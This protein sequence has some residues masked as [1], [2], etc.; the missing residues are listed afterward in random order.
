[1][2]KRM[3]VREFLD[4]NE[5]NILKGARIKPD[6]IK[7]MVLDA[8]HPDLRRMLRIFRETQYHN[9]F[10]RLLFELPFEVC[11]NTIYGQNTLSKN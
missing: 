9:I 10:L 8:E 5:E 11:R 2:E 1:M 6:L 3:R 4:S 7:K